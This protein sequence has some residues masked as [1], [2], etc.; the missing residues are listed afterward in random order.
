MLEKVELM[1]AYVRTGN[2]EPTYT[3]QMDALKAVCD[4]Y[5]LHIAVI[6][7]DEDDCDAAFRQLLADFQNK[8]VWGSVLMWNRALWPDECRGGAFICVL[9]GLKFEFLKQ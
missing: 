8:P 7:H 1:A 4:R 3:Q 2:K 9:N 5:G 6:Y